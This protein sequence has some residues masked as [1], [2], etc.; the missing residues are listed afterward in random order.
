MTYPPMLLGPLLAAACSCLS[1]ATTHARPEV[2]GRDA[3]PHG[4]RCACGADQLSSRSFSATVTPVIS[5]LRDL[6]PTLAG[7]STKSIVTSPEPRPV[8]T[9]TVP[10]DLR[11]V[12]R[13]IL[14][15]STTPTL[16]GYGSAKSADYCVFLPHENEETAFQLARAL[17]STWSLRV[18]RVEQRGERNVRFGRVELDPNR[19]FTLKGL[20]ASLAKV[21]KPAP[22]NALKA[23][24]QSFA[25]A[26]KE[27]VLD[28]MNQARV[29]TVI[30]LHNNTDGDYSIEAYRPG[31]SS[32]SSAEPGK[33][34]IHEDQDPDN[35]IVTTDAHVFEVLR[36]SW[37]VVLQ[38][39]S[40]ADDGSLSVLLRKE[41]YVNV[42]AQ[43]GHYEIQRKMWEAVVDALRSTQ[44]PQ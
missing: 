30:A 33:V 25:K 43:H 7:T 41:S 22:A 15:A 32:A 38:S 40:P 6:A 35:F 14:V 23:A 19:M 24:P 27:A 13:S 34:I 2:D 21:N 20:A 44:V 18:V 26:V 11:Y 10:T 29:R 9:A 8:V 37:N 36:P 5:A 16:A 31:G 3:T 39:P 4:E 42:E 17:L 12:E 28:C 1:C